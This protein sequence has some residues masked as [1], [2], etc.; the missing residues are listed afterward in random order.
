MG[1]KLRSPIMLLLAGVLT[2]PAIYYA[3][4]AI[5]SLYKA[6]SYNPWSANRHF[7]YDYSPGDEFKSAL[8]FL[9]MTAIFAG[10]AL[11]F[12]LRSGNADTAKPYT[13]TPAH[14]YYTRP[15]AYTPPPPPPTPP[16]QPPNAMEAEV[17]RQVKAQLAQI[18][19]QGLGMD[20]FEQHRSEVYRNLSA[21]EREL[22]EMRIDMALTTQTVDELVV[23]LNRLLE[24]SQRR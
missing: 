12:F 17:A 16:V 8:G 1:G 20:T 5:K 14:S 6:L 19:Q 21:H 22:M 2:L 7:A 15:T 23:S 18:Q 10:A 9:L 24:E 13:P 11:Y 3:L 4:R